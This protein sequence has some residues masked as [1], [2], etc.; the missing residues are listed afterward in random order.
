MMENESNKAKTTDE[1]LNNIFADVSPY[2]K[3]AKPSE[4]S[5]LP[6]HFQFNTD[7]FSRYWETYRQELKGRPTLTFE[8]FLM[9][10]DRGRNWAY[11][12]MFG[13]ALNAGAYI[14]NNSENITICQS[15]DN[16][17]WYKIKWADSPAVEYTENP[18]QAVKW[19]GFDGDFKLIAMNGGKATIKSYVFPTG[20]DD[21]SQSYNFKSN[22][23]GNQIYKKEVFNIYY[24][25]DENVMDTENPVYQETL[26]IWNE[27]L[28][29]SPQWAAPEQMQWLNSIAAK[30]Q[31]G[32]NS[33]EYRLA[34]VEFILQNLAPP[35]T[36]LKDIYHPPKYLPKGS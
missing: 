35:G 3:S 12:S 32:T 15:S 2:P 9:I 19:I 18:N 27:L 4:A 26:R 1:I 29:N 11:S 34:F 23:Y 24:L 16:K 31:G 10:A 30:Y 6:K 20:Q 17:G 25:I 7:A 13:K 14:T 5:G 36:K 28:N 8:Q 33:V 22:G 21:H